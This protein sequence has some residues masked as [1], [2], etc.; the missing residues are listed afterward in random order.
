M[1]NYCIAVRENEDDLIFLRKIVPGGADKSYGIA[2]AKLAGV[3]AQVTDRAS[4]IAEELALSDITQ[5]ASRIRAPQPE[6]SKADM[7]TS[8]P[9]N[10]VPTGELQKQQKEVIKQIRD[11]DLTRFTPMEAF[12]LL[13][14]LQGKLRQP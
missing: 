1:H 14:E 5:A 10:S 3:P 2:V 11:L 12:F 4:E 7:N 8:G 13:N 9:D 6:G